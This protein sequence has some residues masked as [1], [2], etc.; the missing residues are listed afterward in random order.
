MQGWI[1]KLT[2]HFH[3]GHTLLLQDI[4]QL[5]VKALVAAMERLGLIT[6]GIE[7]LTG[8]L[9]VVDNRKISLRLSR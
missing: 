2:D 9:K 1:E 6:L 5:L 3:P 4:H 8:S 7:L